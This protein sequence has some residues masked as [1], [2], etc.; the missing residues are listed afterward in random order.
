MRL[1]LPR[2]LNASACKVSKHSKVTSK[3]YL[4]VP[5]N[6]NSDTDLRAALARI[7]LAAVLGHVRKGESKSEQQPCLNENYGYIIV[8]APTVGGCQR[9]QSPGQLKVCKIYIY[10]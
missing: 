3:I 9:A 2:P 6:S 7:D 5:D 4:L 1:V 8:P 10:R